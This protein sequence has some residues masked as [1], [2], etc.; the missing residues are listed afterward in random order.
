MLGE[1]D[2]LFL[3][4]RVHLTP[5]FHLPLQTHSLLF[6]SLYL[7][8]QSFHLLLV[9]LSLELNVVLC[10]S[11]KNDLI[12]NLNSTEQAEKNNE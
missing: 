12:R 5:L 9:V 2:D 10:N 3:Q 8:F 4:V 1:L 6:Q 7:L 11:A